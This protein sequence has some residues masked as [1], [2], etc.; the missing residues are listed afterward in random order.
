MQRWRLKFHY[1]RLPELTRLLIIV[2]L[3][4]FTLGIAI[5]IIEPETF[6]TYFDGIWWATVTSA[7]V[8]YGDYVP[9]TV[10][11]KLTSILLIL[12]GTGFMTYFLTNLAKNIMSVQLAHRNGEAF[13]KGVHHMIVIGWNE[14]SKQ[15]IQKLL[16][17]KAVEHPIV[18]IDQS[19]TASPIT[20][21]HFIKGEPYEDQT[22]IQAN[23]HQARQLIVTSDPSVKEKDADMRTIMTLLSARAL[24]PDIYIIAEILT[25]SQFDNA[26]RAGA[27]QIIQT[28]LITT[29]AFTDLLK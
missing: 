25:P 24:N 5:H 4:I 18:L 2:T 28:A 27:D 15:I 8:G 6:E 23:I 14:R 11:G 21:L 1:L 9:K 16:E 22:L 10:I 26:N 7:T 17:S 20:Q 13:Y 12:M 29:Q 3:L 19:L